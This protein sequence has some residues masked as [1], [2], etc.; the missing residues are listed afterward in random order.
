MK[1]GL[2]DLLQWPGEHDPEYYDDPST[3]DPVRA[4]DLYDEHLEL[5]KAA[6]DL[7]FDYVFGGEHH[8]TG[9]GLTPDPYILLAPLARE[10]KRIRIGA[11]ISTLP[12]HI[13]V[14]L[15]EQ[16]AML[17]VL[18]RGRLDVGL[19]RGQ[20]VVEFAGFRMDTEQAWPAFVEGVEVI[21]KAWSG[22]RFSHEGTYSQAGPVAI[23]PQPFQDPRPPVWIAATSPSSV[24][25]TAR[26]GFNLATSQGSPEVLGERLA[27]HER[28]AAEAGHTLPE[29]HSLIN[30]FVYVAETDEKAREIAGPGFERFQKWFYCQT[31]VRPGERAAR[32]YEEHYDVYSGH[33]KNWQLSSLDDAIRSYSAIIGS[34]ATVTEMLRTIQSTAGV[35]TLLCSTD[36]NLPVELMHDSLRLF[37]REVMPRLQEPAAV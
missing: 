32:G 17:D 14:R 15:A 29:N 3:F 19:G 2:L 23:W 9:Y 4:A 5:W 35:G 24:E 13:P 37:A 36:L 10:T 31:L 6:E 26:K 18:S 21:E 33:T 20:A 27:R 22:E 12:Y 25:W 11:M 30:R 34:P 1:F 28:I 16:L 7:G 8:F